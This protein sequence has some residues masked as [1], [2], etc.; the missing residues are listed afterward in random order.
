MTNET[1]ILI[2]KIIGG[3]AVWI[4]S[5]WLYGIIRDKIGRH[6]RGGGR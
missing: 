6:K 2:L 5:V 3:V 4:F 1:V